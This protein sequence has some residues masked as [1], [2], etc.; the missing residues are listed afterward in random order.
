MRKDVLL[1]DMLH[2]LRACEQ[3]GGL[4]PRAAQQQRSS[5]FAESTGKSLKRGQTRS[6]ERRHVA[7]S[8]NHD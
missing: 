4:L 6:I 7:Q 8:Q 2:E 3:F 1:A 5:R